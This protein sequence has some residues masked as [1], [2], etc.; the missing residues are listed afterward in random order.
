MDKNDYLIKIGNSSD[1]IKI[2]DDAAVRS[3]MRRI[4]DKKIPI[5]LVNCDGRQLFEGDIVEIEQDMKIIRRYE[6]DDN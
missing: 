3:I 4:K 6:G 5:R 2:E 1:M